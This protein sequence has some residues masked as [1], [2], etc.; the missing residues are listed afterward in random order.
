MTYSIEFNENEVQLV[1]NALAELPAKTS[2]ALISKIGGEIAKS[3]NLAEEKKKKIEKK[4][5]KT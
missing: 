4:L 2:M 1:I 3:K 5:T